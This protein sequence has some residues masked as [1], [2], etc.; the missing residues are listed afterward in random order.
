MAFAHKRSVLDWLR[1]MFVTQGPFSSRDLPRTRAEVELQAARAEP[2]D[3]TRLGLD[4]E[5]KLDR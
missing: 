2:R 4:G 5:S 1:E 3:L